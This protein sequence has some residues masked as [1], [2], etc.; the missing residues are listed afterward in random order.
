MTAEIILMWVAVTFYVVGTALFVF[1]VT[2][3]KPKM[4]RLALIVSGA[5]LIPQL[6][7]W[8]IRWQR[9]GHGPS[10][11]FYELTS[12]LTFVTV[13]MFIVVAWRYPKV[14]PAGIIIMPLTLLFVG[15]SMLAPKAGLPVTPTL[16]SYWLV[17]HVVFSDLAFGAF[18]VA[19]ALAV[20]FVIRSRS[21]DGPWAKRFERFPPQDQ[22]DHLSSQLV[23]AGFLFWGV[24][25]ASGSIWAN[26]AWGR[27]W[28]WDPIETWSLV[29][30]LIYAVYLH[31]RFTLGWRG[32]R[33]AWVAIAAMPVALFCLAGIPI[34]YHTVHAGY[35]AL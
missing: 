16:A 17:V 4:V 5:G 29:V 1:G 11:G 18:V 9:L 22:V 6:S 26:Q 25:I 7:A 33:L 27:Y 20:V 34:V 8:I 19:F 35:L 3:S 13:A 12:E 31:L 21:V 23:L 32:E 24:M 2:L 28:G 30:W 14:A 15:A 10:L